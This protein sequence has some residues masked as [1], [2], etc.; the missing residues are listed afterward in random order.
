MSSLQPAARAR[1]RLIARRRP[2]WRGK[3]PLALVLLALA[4]LVL[5]L[6]SAQA[7]QTAT[8]KVGLSPY[9]LKINTALTFEI[10]IGST[11]GAVPSPVTGVS[12][13]L[14]DGMGLSTSQ[15][16]LAVCDSETL[17]VL[18]IAGCPQEAVMGLGTAVMKI[19]KGSESLELP[20]DLTAVMAPAQNEHTTLLFYAEGQSGVIAELVFP[21]LMLGDS[22]P[23]GTRIDFTIPPVATVPGDSA[24]SLISMRVT[25]DPKQLL[26]PERLHG[27]QVHYH[28]RGM[29][30]P[31]VCPR[32]G[33]P[34][35]ANLHF[36]DGTSVDATTRVACP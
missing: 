12:L 2:P 25:V 21:G 19:A 9:R 22:G 4:L 3:V 5:P 18:G 33:F 26:Y 34:F 32:D 27:K 1:I 31:A 30:V 28:P 16:G 13:Q 29:A 17:R 14:P 15:L 10:H 7:A 11:G 36:E 24:A 20:I 8:L 35:A 23:F 6:G